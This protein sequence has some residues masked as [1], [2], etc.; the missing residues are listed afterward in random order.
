[1]ELQEKIRQA[2]LAQNKPGKGAWWY[3]ILGVMGIITSLIIA[4]FTL[5]EF[6]IVACLEYLL[7]ATPILV[8]LA[9]YFG[10][11][12][13]R[14]ARAARKALESGEGRYV[15]VQ[16]TGVELTQQKPC[17]DDSE[18]EDHSMIT[19]AAQDA[20]YSLEYWG[21]LE[22]ME[23]QQEY[24]LVL[25]GEDNGISMVYCP[26]QDKLLYIQN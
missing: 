15:T 23:A 20:E 16:C 24:C 4:V 8:I 14:T 6:E 19:F 11:R 21:E 3:A 9:W 10:I 26:R 12:P 17:G 5:T 22:G 13:I 2:W 7:I 1:M 18:P 25:L